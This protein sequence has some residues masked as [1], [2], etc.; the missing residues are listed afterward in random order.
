M[1]KP[2]MTAAHALSRLS[3]DRALGL[4]PNMVAY[5]RS[6]GYVIIPIEP[7]EG[8]IDELVR[9][10]WSQKTRNIGE[11]TELIREGLVTFHGGTQ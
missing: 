5:L 2:K 10:G 1:T 7:G 4:C 3:I 8:E 11:R 9:F 6:L